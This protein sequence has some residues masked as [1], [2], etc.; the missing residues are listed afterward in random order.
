MATGTVERTHEVLETRDPERGV[1]SHRYR[2]TVN[3]A[4][5]ADGEPI[6]SY[7]GEE[8]A[9]ERVEPIPPAI[10]QD[11]WTG[12]VEVSNGDASELLERLDAILTE[13]A[14]GLTRRELGAASVMVDGKITGMDCIIGIDELEEVI[15]DWLLERAA[16]VAA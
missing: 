5:N 4:R 11:R 6:E 15:R 16:K 1:R 12:L 10:L 8:W 13:L 14:E 3:G 9:T 7:S 2:W